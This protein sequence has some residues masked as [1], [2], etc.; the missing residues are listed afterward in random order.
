MEF[1]NMFNANPT[2]KKIKTNNN[3]RE[4]TKTETANITNSIEYT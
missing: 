3:H 4:N 2:V 1:C